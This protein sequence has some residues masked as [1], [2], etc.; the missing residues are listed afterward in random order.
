MCRAAYSSG[1]SGSLTR[2][3][4]YG[5]PSLNIRAVVGQAG[6][7]LHSVGEGTLDMDNSAEGENYYVARV[8]TRLKGLTVTVLGIPERA[9]SQ[10]RQVNDLVARVVQ[11]PVHLCARPG[12]VADRSLASL[13][14]EAWS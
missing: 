8:T 13:S 7:R 6:M 12:D 2:L 5:L 11:K 4:R 10:R 9:S 14:D 1:Y 3:H